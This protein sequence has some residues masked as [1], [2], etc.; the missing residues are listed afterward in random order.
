MIRITAK[1]RREAIEACM[2]AAYDLDCDE[3]MPTAANCAFFAVPIDAHKDADDGV[4][5]RFRWQL[6]WLEAAALLRGDDDHDPWSPGDP[7][8]LLAKDRP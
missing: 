4:G 1:Q 2:C 5:R 8:Y 3:L 6:Q 7:V